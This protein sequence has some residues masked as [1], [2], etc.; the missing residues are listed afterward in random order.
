MP[1]SEE[2][3]SILACPAC[4][5]RPPLRQESEESLVCDK[6]HRHYPIRDGIIELLV[7]EETSSPR[8]E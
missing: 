6:C 5:D 8:E 3:L 4:D 7:E 2:L 1:L